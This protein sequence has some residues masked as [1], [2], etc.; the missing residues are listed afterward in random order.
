MLHP[1]IL[2][3]KRVMV[4]PHATTGWAVAGTVSG[5][6]IWRQTQGTC[7]GS[8]L[9]VF[10]ISAHMSVAIMAAHVRSS[11]TEQNCLQFIR[12]HQTGARAAP[13]STSVLA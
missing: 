7:M 1:F 3:N 5:A 11:V 6:V 4:A 10:A 8:L 2:A 13:S 9:T 12:P